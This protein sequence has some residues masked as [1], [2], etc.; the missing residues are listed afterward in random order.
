[1]RK[2]NESVDLVF[3]GSG[4]LLPCHIGAWSALTTR[5]F[6]VSRVAG[7]SGG[8]IVAASLA[9]G[10]D[11][12]RAL[13][14]ATEFLA[15][16]LLDSSWWFFDR[17]GIHKWNKIR[18]LLD[19]H[20]PG[21]MSQTKIPL[22]IFVVDLETR[23][24]IE[25]TS[26]G[27]PNVKI[28]DALAATSAIPAFAKVQEIEHVGRFLVDGGVTTN[29]AMGSF[30]DVMTRRTIGV[31]IVSTPK[32]KPIRSTSDWAS[33]VISSMHEAAN[34]SYVSK[35]KFQNVIEIHSSGDGMD[36]TLDKKQVDGMFREGRD[37]AHRWAD[38]L[39]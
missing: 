3:S 35:K 22:K 13:A 39:S 16:D 24:P 20:I 34:R 4:T 33:A 23:K 26:A 17:Y 25:L 14:L 9:V 8:G 30:D 18:S 21:T 32:P 28:S 37:A 31:R 12:G 19:E 7:T 5:G 11:P 36:F 29:F 15:G 38:S 27:T 6:K 10:M 2:F 1:M